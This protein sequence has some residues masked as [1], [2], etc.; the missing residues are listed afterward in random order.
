MLRTCGW[1]EGG[2]RGALKQV[3]TIRRKHP[4]NVRAW[5][6]RV[7]SNDAVAYR[8]MAELFDGLALSIRKD[9]DIFDRDVST[10]VCSI[11]MNGT[12]GEISVCDAI[13]ICTN[14]ALDED[15][16]AS[17]SRCVARDGAVNEGEHA[18]TA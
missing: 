5:M 10:A 13:T 15:A 9:V 8:H 3:I 11:S 17:A 12:K 4:H 1:I 16:A 7:T 2:T 14:E 18:A 6:S